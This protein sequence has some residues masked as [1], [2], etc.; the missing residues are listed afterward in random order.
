MQHSVKNIGRDYEELSAMRNDKYQFKAADFFQFASENKN[1]Y[2]IVVNDDDL[3]VSSWHSD[4]LIND[5][6][7]LIKT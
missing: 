1:K 4:T 6:R 7:T 5:Y 2:S 3:L